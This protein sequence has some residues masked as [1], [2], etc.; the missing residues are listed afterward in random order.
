VDDPVAD[1]LQ[2][3]EKA[4]EV[5][6]PP[7][8]EGRLAVVAHL[9]CCRRVSPFAT[10]NSIVAWPP[11]LST[12]PRARDRSPSAALKSLTFKIELPQLMV[13]ILMR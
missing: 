2:A 8:L 6:Q 4:R 13:R 1:G 9:G 5:E 10:A 7:R 11:I 3:A 12:T